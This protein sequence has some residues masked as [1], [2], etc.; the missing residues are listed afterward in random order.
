[1]ASGLSSAFSACSGLSELLQGLESHGAPSK[2]DKPSALKRKAGNALL[3]PKAKPKPPPKGKHAT[4]TAAVLV[5]EP[6]PAAAPAAKPAAAPAAKPAAAKP[7][8]APT[9][10]SDSRNCVHSRAYKSAARIARDAGLSKAEISKAAC[11]AG[12]EAAAKWDLDHA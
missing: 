9:G 1:M 3:V 2:A 4:E 12:R 11:K 7:A 8:D 5:P 6:E 10:L